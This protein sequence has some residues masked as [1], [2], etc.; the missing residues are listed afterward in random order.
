M[1]IYKVVQMKK[2]FLT[3]LFISVGFIGSSQSLAADT[4]FKNFQEIQKKIDSLSVV[5][6]D[7]QIRDLTSISTSLRDFNLKGQINYET[8][9]TYRNKLNLQKEACRQAYKEKKISD[10]WK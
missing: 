2:N 8:Y 7:C 3:A 5:Q 9:K 6:E 10:I 4:N 1:I